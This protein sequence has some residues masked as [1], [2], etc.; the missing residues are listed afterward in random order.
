MIYN[1]EKEVSQKQKIQGI[2]RNIIEKDY[3]LSWA[4]YGISQ[5]DDLRKSLIFKGGTCLK[6]C[7]FGDYRYSEDLDFSVV[8]PCLTNEVFETYIKQACRIAEI[9]LGQRY[10]N[11]LLQSEMYHENKPHPEN[12]IAFIIRAQ[13]P[14]QRKLYTKIKIEITTQ[15]NAIL[16]TVNR[17]IIHDYEP[18]YQAVIACYSIEE[19]ILEK[20]RAILQYTKKIHE[21]DWA[22]SRARDYYDLWSILQKYEICLS[23]VEFQEELKKKCAPKAVS[24]SAI[25]DFFDKQVMIVVHKEWEQWLRPLVQ[26]LPSAEKV[27]DTLYQKLAQLFV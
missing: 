24:F 19:I 18:D 3:L 17:S 22:R 20:L 10:P 21:S 14:W 12:Q 16:P 2:T 4:L 23:N 25:D 5:I 11:V 27:I 9:E 7:Y 15:E 8:N 6:K 13:L 26:N 1:L